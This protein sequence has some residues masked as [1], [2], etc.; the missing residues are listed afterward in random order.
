[1]AGRSTNATLLRDV[2]T[3]F[4]FGVARDVSDRELL[5]RF[6]FADRAV[7]EAAFTF[8]VERHGPMVLSACGQFL[9]DPYD[10]EDAFQ[11]TFLVFLRRA[12]SIRKRDSLA[13]WLFGVAT[14]VAR[15]RE[16]AQRHGESMSDRP[17]SSPS[18]TGSAQADTPTGWQHCTRRLHD[19]RSGTES[20]S[21]S[22]ISKVYPQRPR[23]AGWAAPT[24][25]FF[26]GWRA[27]AA[28]CAAR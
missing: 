4:E 1:M 14:H 23:R 6:L 3:I 28:A 7:A 16:A 27:L 11:A 25:R 12:H 24:G 8:L 18:R 19:F 22:A 2:R 20:R 17:A 15:R 21:C 5:D 9:D 26:P 13:S 10:V